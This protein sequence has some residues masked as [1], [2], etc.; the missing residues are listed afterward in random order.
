MDKMESVAQESRAERIARYKAERRRELAERYGSQEEE[1]PS[2]WSRRER[3]GRGGRDST[4]VD[5]SVSGGMNGGM[6][7]NGQTPLEERPVPA[8]I[9]NGCKVNTC[10]ENTQQNR[11]SLLGSSGTVAGENP[12]DFHGP[13]TPDTPQLHTHVSVGQ[14]KDALLQ[15]TS[16]P[17]PS[18]RVATDDGVVA[19]N[20][21]LAVQPGAEGS[22]LRTRRY[23]SGD[24]AGCRKNSERF[25]TQPV[26]ACEIKDSCGRMDDGNQDNSQM[27][28]KTDDRA[29]MSVAAKMSLFKELEKTASPE[30]S[31]FLKPRSSNSF[32][33]R[34]VRRNYD[35]R[36]LTQPITFEE[37][38]MAASPQAGEAEPEV[39]DDA[40]TKLSMSEKLALFNKLSQPILGAVGSPARDGSPLEASERRRQKGARYRTQPITV[41]EVNLLQKGPVELPRLHLAPHLSDRQQAESIN[42]KPSEVRLSGL[43]SSQERGSSSELTSSPHLKPASDSYS[44]NAVQIKGILKKSSSEGVVWR[45]ES[46]DRDN[47]NGHGLEQNGRERRER[48]VIEERHMTPVD[49]SPAPLSSTPWRQRARKEASASS[50]RARRSA[51]KPELCPSLSEDLQITE[52]SRESAISDRLTDS[53]GAEKEEEKQNATE[54]CNIS[55][56][57]APQDENVTTAESNP[58]TQCWEP[59]FSSVYSRSSSTPQYVMFFNERSLSYEAQEVCTTT[60][61]QP[62]VTGRVKASC[63][64]EDSPKLF[65]ETQTVC[66]SEVQE[67][68]MFGAEM[69]SEPAALPACLTTGGDT[70][71]DLSTLCQTNTPILSSAVAEHRRSV[72]PSRRTQGSRNPLRALAA[73]EDIQQDFM[74]SEENSEM[75]NNTAMKNS[76]CTPADVSSSGKGSRPTVPYNKLML[77][78]VKGWRQVQVRLVEPVSRSLNSGDCF[79]L[80]TPSHCFLW[81]G[82]LSNTIEREKASEMASVI[83][84]QRDLGCQATGVI[85]L[86][87]GVNTDS[88]QAAEFWNLLGGQTQYKGPDSADDDEHYERAISESNCIY[89]LQGVRLSPHEQGWA[90]VPDLSLLNSSQTLLFDFGSELYLWHGKDVGPSERKLALQL[91]Q[92][93]WDGA[94]D[95]SNCRINPL[96]PSGGSAHIHKQGIGRPDWALFGRVFD[97]N[98]TILFKEKFTQTNVNK[99]NIAPSVQEEV[100][101]PSLKSSPQP[102]SAEQWSC[103]ARALFGGVCLSGVSQIVL[104]GVDVRRG[105]DSV[106]LSDGRQAEL[107]TLAV[108]TWLISE[109]EECE[110][111]PESLGQFNEGSTYAVCWTYS[112]TALGDQMAIGQERSALFIWKGRH[113]NVSGRGLSSALTNQCSSQVFVTEGEEPPCFLQ[114][115]Q[116]GMVI[117]RQQQSR[118]TGGWHLFCV[119]GDVPVEGRLL[120]VQCSCSSL[121]SRGSLILL[122]SQQGAIYLWHGCKAHSKARQ[123]AKQTVQRLTQMCPPELSLRTGRFMNVQEVEDGKEPADFWNAIGPQDRKSYDCMLQDPG[124]FNFTPRLYHLSAQSGTFKGVELISPSH[125][126]GVITAMPFLQDKLY[127]VPHPALFLLDN[128]LEVYLWQS[129]ESSVSQRPHWD[130][131]KKCAMETALQYCKER[132]PRRPPMA[133]L[134]EEGA[135]PLTFTNIFP[136]WEM[137]LTQEVQDCTV[138]KKLTLVQDALAALNTTQFPLKDLLKRPLPEGVDPLHLENYLSQHDFKVALGMTWNDYNCLS[139]LQKMDLKKSKGLY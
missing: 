83:V 43:S 41:D 20:L 22:R 59:V 109:G 94:Y 138:R 89:R 111:F 125:V 106:T 29:K 123:V 7:R 75:E 58:Q 134:I 137:R 23:M 88:L 39:E 78:Q 122:N 52:Q 6:G 86:D 61:T 131:E 24:S 71:S 3:E 107:C 97:Q 132:N 36:A 95:Y 80:V 119:K 12:P 45:S 101:T 120:E 33:E 42:L 117:Y 126:N 14:L 21:D 57:S 17:A 84:T 68:Q 37:T 121:R 56:S 10:G 27:D 47:L 90:V 127:A 35:P 133:Y 63:E 62:L 1:L 30:A 104:D 38:V 2:K 105:W 73:R 66:A 91:A 9:S 77:M 74:Q 5:K 108:K 18:D 76:N 26:T 4:Y 49:Q 113:S 16:S 135:E 32:H 130:R 50:G 129:C 31:S 8:K 28:V 96:D 128:Y 118:D 124:K 51:P 70:E 93:V 103:D 81:T 136:S 79:L 92:Q 114:L 67:S 55:L 65:A 69:T 112:L 25:R 19:L 100:K 99:N 54:R 64:E 87:E 11:E 72:R 116:G 102:V 115:F 110:V 53:K 15:Q 85:H 34:R 44:Q 60:Q 40:G 98:E 48:E 46:R 13:S 139:D 82:K